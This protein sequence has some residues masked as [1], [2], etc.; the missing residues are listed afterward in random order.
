MAGRDRT[1]AAAASPSHRDQICSFSPV[2]SDKFVLRLQDDTCAEISANAAN[3]PL[4][5]TNPTVPPTV[6]QPSPIHAEVLMPLKPYVPST[7]R[8]SVGFDDLKQSSVCPDYLQNSLFAL[9]LES[10]SSRAEYNRQI[11]L[12]M[13]QELNFW[14]EHVQDSN[15][16]VCSSEFDSETED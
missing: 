10:A 7:K 6:M 8:M 16:Q 5:K 15:L 9:S 3:R 12:L 13:Q 1:Y 2:W 14:D 4:F 11:G